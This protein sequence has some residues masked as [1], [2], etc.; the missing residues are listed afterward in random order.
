MKVMDERPHNVVDVIEDMS[1]DV[2][3]SLFE[4]KQYSL[5]ELPQ[6]IAAEEL[7]E[8][9]RL[10]FRQPEDAKQEYNLVL[11]IHTSSF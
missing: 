3:R 11:Q 4:N 7:A 10:L 2:K 9:Q 1:C 8:Q 5:Q 6:I